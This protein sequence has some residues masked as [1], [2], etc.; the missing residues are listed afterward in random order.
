MKTRTEIVGEAEQLE[1][2]AQEA[3]TERRGIAPESGIPTDTTSVVLV[4]LPASVMT[5]PRADGEGVA[6]HRMVRRIDVE[7]RAGRPEFRL[8]EEEF[9]NDS[10]GGLVRHYE[11]IALLTSTAALDVLASGYR[12][13]DEDRLRERVEPVVERMAE[14][15]SPDTV[16]REAIAEIEAL[17]EDLE[18]SPVARMRMRADAMALLRG[19][20]ETGDFVARTVER[21]EC[22]Q[23]GHSEIICEQ[24]TE[25]LE[26]A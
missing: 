11:A 18:L 7:F 3:W 1:R 4:E 26:V 2:R 24:I 23:V 10:F 15:D 25:R 5:L 8:M 14:D 9:V 13:L 6:D 17:T 21:Q 16:P 20:L 22:Y 12:R 19:Q